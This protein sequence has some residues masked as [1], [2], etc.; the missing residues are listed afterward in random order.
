MAMRTGK[1]VD[2][3]EEWPLELQMDLLVDGELPEGERAVLLRSM[4][5]RPGAWRELGVR[6]LRRQVE[7][8][9]VKRLMAGGTLVEVEMQERVPV[10]RILWNWMG[11]GAA[12]ATAAGL[13]IATASVMIT[14]YTMS[15]PRSVGVNLVGTEMYRGAIPAEAVGMKE[16]L[17]VEVPLTQVQAVDGNLLRWDL[18]GSWDDGQP[19]SRKWVIQPGRNGQDAI[20]I[21]VEMS[22]KIY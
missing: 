8:E 1:M 11:S 5:A 16:N 19:Q 7:Q 4:D 12:R 18:S 20:V 22:R 3:P 2:R 14:V 17:P 21:P 10:Y 15:G 13:L 6:F 9:T